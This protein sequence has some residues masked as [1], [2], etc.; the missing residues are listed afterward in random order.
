MHLQK[1][2]DNLQ[3]T[4]YSNVFQ[5]IQKHIENTNIPIIFIVLG[6][7]QASSA[8]GVLKYTENLQKN[9]YSK[10]FQKTPQKHWK[11]K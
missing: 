1:N 4:N 11:N 8:P 7:P 9:N 10:V 2:T 6:Q 5:K 3:K